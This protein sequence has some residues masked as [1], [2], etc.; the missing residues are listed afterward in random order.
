VTPHPSERLSPGRRR[1][2]VI[3]SGVAGLTA[4]WVLHRD[5]DVTLYEADPRLG[6]H[7]D[8][9]DVT[10]S[11]GGTLAVDTGFIVHNETTY[12]TLIRLF[13]ELG[14]RTQDSDMSMSVHC[15]ECG[16]EYA[17]GR[18][19]SGLVAR[20]GA[21]ARRGYLRMLTEVPRFHRAARTLL[22]QPARPGTPE[23]D[24]ARFLTEHRFS[25]YF[26]RH[27]MTPLVSAVWSCPAEV[28]AL[29][30][31]RYLFTFLANHGMLSVTGSPTWRTVV[32]G[33]R[34]YVERVAKPLQA[35]H[36]ATPVRGLHR[37]ADGVDVTDDGGT[38]TCFDAAVVATHPDQALA[39]LTEPTDAER[40]LLGAFSYSQNEAVLHRDPSLLPTAGRA[41][42]SW[43]YRMATCADPAGQVLV[44]YHMNR[45]QRLPAA[46]DLIV[47]LN[48]GD[49]VAPESV[50]DRMSYAHPTF[51]AESVAAQTELASLNGPRLA[52]AGAYHGWGFH[53]DGARAGLAAATALG[54][55]W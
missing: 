42:A 24:V 4:A 29:Y 1:V 14:V 30:P 39:L 50:I 19:V 36:T 31:A 20:P 49:R 22:A 46:E 9:H 26:A 33:S 45:L 28:S 37:H 41:R 13:G 18:G 25:R 48:P 47:T 5:H 34:S 40:R 2:A 32:G 7:A 23:P 21:L 51:T 6:G 55:S 52:F 3:G 10:S 43:N 54:A 11:S 35:V 27:F 12:P 44:S 38:R 15:D 17:G 53:E 16:L 8:T